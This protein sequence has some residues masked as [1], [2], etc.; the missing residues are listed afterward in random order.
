MYLI[1]FI[2][3]ILLGPPSLLRLQEL[4]FLLRSLVLLFSLDLLLSLYSLY[5]WSSLPLPVLNICYFCFSRLLI[6]FFARF[7]IFVTFVT[8]VGRPSLVRFKHFLVFFSLA[9][10][11]VIF[12]RRSQDFSKGGHTVSKWGYS[13]DCHVDLHAVLL[14]QTKVLKKGPFNY[15]QDI[16]MAFSPPVLGCLVKR[17]LQKRRSRAPQDHPVAT[18]LFSLDL[19]FSLFLW[20]LWGPLPLSVLSVWNICYLCLCCFDLL[21]SPELQNISLHLTATLSTFEF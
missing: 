21:F 16:V 20:H 6:C 19:S 12:H 14:I 9:S 5:L 11:F 8:V 7:V 1:H 10:W 4:L 13:P 18:P 3:V 2:F 15:R 17:G